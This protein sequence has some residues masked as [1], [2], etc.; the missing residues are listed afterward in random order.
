M[1][2]K[3]WGSSCVFTRSSLPRVSDHGSDKCVELVEENPDGNDVPFVQRSP[4]DFWW[5]ASV[6][7]PRQI[8]GAVVS[9]WIRSGSSSVVRVSRCSSPLGPW[10]ASRWVRERIPSWNSFRGAFRFGGCLGMRAPK[11][12]GCGSVALHATPRPEGIKY[13]FIA[14]SIF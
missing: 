2:N 8:S 7:V 12:V 3:I 14:F 6:C 9:W 10:F 4:L 5:F 13:Y 11:V 1:K